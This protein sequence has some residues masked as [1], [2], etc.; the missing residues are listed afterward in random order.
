MILFG[1]FERHNF[2]DI[3]M[4]IIFENLLLKKGIRS[5]HASILENDLRACGGRKVYSIFK[6]F[7]SGLDARVPILH[8]GGQTIPISFETA[9]LAD[10]PRPLADLRFKDPEICSRMASQLG[11]DRV[12]P[13]ITPAREMING[14][15]ADWTNRLYYGIGFTRNI[16]NPALM[17]ELRSPLIESKQIGFRDGVSLG[18]T[19][20]GKSHAA[21]LVSAIE[22]R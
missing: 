20:T 5:I 13:Y 4:G 17:S 16:S 21:Q 14:R 22:V 11:T 2:G 15:M 3:L 7:T 1:A 10:S 8:V 6:L 18:P 19:E 9:L 12:L